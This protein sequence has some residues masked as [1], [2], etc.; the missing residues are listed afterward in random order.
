MADLLTHGCVALLAGLAAGL[1]ERGDLAVLVA[2]SCV[3]DLFGQV[4]GLALIR[5]RATW[6]AIPEPLIYLF[7][8]LHLP[9]GLVVLNY[10]LAHGFAPPERFRVFGLLTAG[11]FLHLAVDL[12][13][14]HFGVGY[15]LFFPFT[16]WDWEAGLVGTEATV[17]VAP[18]LLLLTAGL[19]WWL[20]RRRVRGPGAGTLSPGAPAESGGAG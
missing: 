8:P 11:G 18:V 13:Q 19:T 7:S 4:P 16:R 1:R 10:A 20:R 17:K 14:S 5:V 15:M 3:P 9:S 6:P 2:G 12:L